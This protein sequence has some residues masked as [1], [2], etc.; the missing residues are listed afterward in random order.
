ME[1]LAAVGLASNVVQFVQFLSS[2]IHTAVEIHRSSSGI[3]QDILTLDDLYEQ[4]TD[5]N[6]KLESSA[7]PAEGYLNGP[8]RETVRGFV[9]DEESGREFVNDL[10]SFR[11][12]SLLAG[13]TA[14]NS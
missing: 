11:T 12:V 5:F 3:T 4:L 14:T 7:L 10:P 2:L 13:R 1:P 8:G 9:V 6:A